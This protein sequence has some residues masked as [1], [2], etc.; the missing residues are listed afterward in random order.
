MVSRLARSVETW[1][2]NHELLDT[3]IIY[4]VPKGVR[5]LYGGYVYLST[6]P[7]TEEVN[8]YLYPEVMEGSLVTVVAEGSA[9]QD[10]Y[11]SDKF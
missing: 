11:F 7:R 6:E 10:E 4:D 1:L 2:R 8:P 3:V 9:L 5:K